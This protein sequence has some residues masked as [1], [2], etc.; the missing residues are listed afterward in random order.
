M[1]RGVSPKALVPFVVIFTDLDGTLLDHETYGW[2]EAKPAL[3]LCK[4]LQVPLI[5]VSSK[6]DLSLYL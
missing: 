3:N 2:E 6:T 5:L 4:A 1:R